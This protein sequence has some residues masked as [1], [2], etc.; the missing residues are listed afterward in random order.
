MLETTW[1]QKDVAVVD[2]SRDLL[3]VPT[4]NASIR[5]AVA[6][7][8]Q[9]LGMFFAS[10]VVVHETLGLCENLANLTTKTKK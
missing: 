4:T 5:I 10:H 6:Q 9:I 8:F 3:W 2:K 7:S 1:C